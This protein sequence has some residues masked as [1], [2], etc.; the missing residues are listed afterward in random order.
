MPNP[1]NLQ[2]DYN[3]LTMRRNISR[4][5]ESL[6]GTEEKDKNIQE[7]YEKL[8]LVLHQLMDAIEEAY[9]VGISTFSDRTITYKEFKKEDYDNL[10]GC[11]MNTAM[12]IMSLSKQVEAP[13]YEALD[14]VLKELYMDVSKDITALQ[15]ISSK[16]FKHPLAVILSESRTICAKNVDLEKLTT[17]GAASSTRYGMNLRTADGKSRPG[18]FTRERVH[19]FQIPHEELDRLMGE[20]LE[21][22]KDAYDLPV[23]FQISQYFDKLISDYALY[24][25]NTANPEKLSAYIYTKNSAADD[26]FEPDNEE[27][28]LSTM[29]KNLT[30]DYEFQNT[31]APDIKIQLDL[32]EKSIKKEISQY[33]YSLKAD[34]DSNITGRNVAMSNVAA[35]LGMPDIVAHSEFMT[36]YEGDKIVKGIFMEMAVGIDYNDITDEKLPLL[37]DDPINNKDF[38][39]SLSNLQVLDYI[40]GNY[41]RH[42]NNMMY[43]M[44]P[45][46]EKFIGVIGIDNDFSFGTRPDG[47]AILRKNAYSNVELDQIQF[48]T[49]EL[50]KRLLLITP[51]ML[52]FSLQACGLTQKE[53]DA[54]VNRLENIQRKLDP[55][56]AVEDKRENAQNSQKGTLR[57]YNDEELGNIKIE[58]FINSAHKTESALDIKKKMNVNDSPQNVKKAD[59]IEKKIAINNPVAESCMQRNIFGRVMYLTKENIKG[60]KEENNGLVKNPKTAENGLY[61][62]VDAEYSANAENAVEVDAEDAVELDAEI[63]K[64]SLDNIKESIAELSIPA[65]LA[66]SENMKALMKE[67]EK[68]LAKLNKPQISDEELIDLNL[69]ADYKT[70]A[71]LGE[72]FLGELKPNMD[73]L[74]GAKGY[75]EKIGACNNMYVLTDIFVKRAKNTAERLEKYMSENA[76]WDEIKENAAKEKGQVSGENEITKRE[77]GVL[78]EKA[79]LAKGFLAAYSKGQVSKIK[80]NEL[81]EYF[82]AF[83][84]HLMIT[85]KNPPEDAKRM[86]E[87]L[88]QKTGAAK[89]YIKKVAENN[90]GMRDLAGHLTP[91]A[92]KVLLTTGSIEKALQAVG[93][94]KEAHHEE[95]AQTNVKQQEPGAAL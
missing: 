29:E 20:Y 71:A 5:L 62:T 85:Q 48:V 79:A 83:T 60:L 34:K 73:M 42:Q 27:S 23:D 1:T 91:K 14:G 3:P 56:R 51:D 87:I 7:G 63:L 75:T 93:L 77:L 19:N 58:D 68:T 66:G 37:S 89:E 49:E 70:I 31:V 92:A 25:T 52:R 43:V 10:L 78:A 45:K 76:R 82:T 69:Q 54:A 18:F 88:T 80:E 2:K 11:Y 81:P 72:K 30:K 28:G 35:L 6:E 39:K 64:N 50:N 61:R 59:G 36:V 32:I 95:A 22:Q 67:I 84:L 41:D 8:C 44:D 86:T 12:A 33:D 47:D 4:Y 53:I 9:S 57:V 26:D 24:L 17:V 94:K 15:G 16:D 90:P 46:K 74:P 13:G 55:I 21:P 65:E 40:C 38:L